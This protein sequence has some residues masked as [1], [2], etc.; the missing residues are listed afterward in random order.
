MQADEFFNWLAQDIM[1]R[2]LEDWRAVQQTRQAVMV[3]TK[4]YRSRKKRR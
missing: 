1:N 3:S 2:W 4:K